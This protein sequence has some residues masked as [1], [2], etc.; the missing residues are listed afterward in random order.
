MAHATDTSHNATAQREHSVHSMR[1]VL[2]LLRPVMRR[3]SA[4]PLVALECVERLVDLLCGYRQP[5]SEGAAQL[6]Q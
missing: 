3:M 6:C 5:L 2:H 4:L 1:H